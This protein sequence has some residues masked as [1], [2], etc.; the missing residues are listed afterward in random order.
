MMV[1]ISTELTPME[2]AKYKAATLIESCGY[3]VCGLFN[4]EIFK[5]HINEKI[6][7]FVAGVKIYPLGK[8]SVNYDLETITLKGNTRHMINIG[9]KL[10]LHGF[11]VKVEVKK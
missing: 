5:F 4:E 2:A 6:S 7:K 8:F 1:E 10:E 3:V 9:E 11:K